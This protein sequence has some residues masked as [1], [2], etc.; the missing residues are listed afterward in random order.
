MIAILCSTCYLYLQWHIKRVR[1]IIL[2]GRTWR[3]A[4]ETETILKSE[5]LMNIA[6]WVEDGNS[7]EIK[8]IFN[9]E[10]MKH[11]SEGKALCCFNTDFHKRKK[12]MYK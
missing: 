6:L 2:Q 3:L 11:G 8:K 4:T 1:N 12:S 9:E 5:R 7:D 10:V